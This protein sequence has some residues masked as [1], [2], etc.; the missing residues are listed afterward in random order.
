MTENMR[1]G[2]AVSASLHLLA[3]ILAGAPDLESAGAS[4]AVQ[5]DLADMPA[6]A[7]AGAGGAVAVQSFTTPPG[8]EAS[9]I[10][11]E[12]RRVY[13]AYLE[14]VSLAV[15]G[16]RLDH[17]NASLIGIARFSFVI[18]AE[19]R[20]SSIC[21]LETSG[22]EQLDAAARRAIERASGEVKR[23]QILGDE[24]MIVFEDVRYQYGL[25]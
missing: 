9:K 10:A 11:Q 19:G 1:I 12:R 23:P 8:D 2:L 22:D 21:L 14:A 25:R 4:Q 7:A 5:I 3:L 24:P 20:F 18:D 16:H 15:H 13:L 6:A 17:G